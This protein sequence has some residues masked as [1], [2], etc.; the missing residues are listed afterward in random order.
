MTRQEILFNLVL[1][2]IIGSL[3]FL[4]LTE[5]ELDNDI[6]VPAAARA[7]PPPP[8]SETEYAVDG[9]LK[10]P[11]FGENDVFVALI[12]P[13]PTPPPP[14]PSPTKTPNIHAALAAWKLSGIMDGEVTVEDKSKPNHP[15]Q[16][17]MMKVGD[18]HPVQVDKGRTGNATLI[19]V[20]EDSDNPSATFSLDGTDET[21][22]LKTIEDSPAAP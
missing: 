21:H 16:F 19:N 15:D 8:K 6:T 12:P 22:M 7:T 18:V 11:K 17:F 13:T 20:D 10:Y 5:E 1:L 14:T 3:A 4:L 2:T 9:Q